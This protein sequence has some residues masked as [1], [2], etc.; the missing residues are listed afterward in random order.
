MTHR[1][2]RWDDTMFIVLAQDRVER[3]ASLLTVL[4]FSALLADFLLNCFR[5]KSHVTPS[6]TIRPMDYYEFCSDYFKCDC[7]FIFEGNSLELASTNP[8]D[9]QKT[10]ECWSVPVSEWVRLQSR[11]ISYKL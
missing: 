5:C 9:G 7:G 11:A 1:R 6:E 8:E 4:S 3:R 10:S 2:L